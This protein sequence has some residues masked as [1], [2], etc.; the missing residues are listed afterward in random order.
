MTVPFVITPS[1]V[2]IGE[3]GFFLTP[4]IGR[5]NV[6]L[7][8]GCVT[9]AFLKRNAC[10]IDDTIKTWNDGVKETL[11]RMFASYIPSVL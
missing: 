3:D 4:M 7:S 1:E 8:S 10:R 9:C 11:H 6:A 5:Q 2:Y